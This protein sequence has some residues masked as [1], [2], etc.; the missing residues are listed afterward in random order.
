MTIGIRSRSGEASRDSLKM[1][2]AP[3]VRIRRAFCGSMVRT[4]LDVI[5]PIVDTLFPAQNCYLASPQCYT[6]R[7]PSRS[8]IERRLLFPVGAVERGYFRSRRQLRTAVFAVACPFCGTQEKCGE[9]VSKLRGVKT[10]CGSVRQSGVRFPVCEFSVGE[11][12]AS[13]QDAPPPLSVPPQP[14]CTAP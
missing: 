1:R 14:S 7:R 8:G 11:W 2:A 10:Q 3:F 12:I 13:F 6:P 4:N 9:N 5:A